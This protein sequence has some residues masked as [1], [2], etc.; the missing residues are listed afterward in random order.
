MSSSIAP[1]PLDREPGV[2]ERVIH[3]SSNS[4]VIF[5][6]SFGDLGGAEILLLADC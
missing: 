2:S 6:F 1:S 5:F 3:A 4:R